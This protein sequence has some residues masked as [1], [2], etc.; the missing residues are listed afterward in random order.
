VTLEE[1]AV[2]EGLVVDPKGQPVPLARVAKDAVPVV[3]VSGTLPPGVAETDA[4]GKFRLGELPSGLVTLEAFAPG[5]GQVLTQLRLY[6]GRTSKD[7]KLTLGE[8]ARGEPEAKGSGG[9][10]VTLGE[11]AGPPAEVGIVTV[12]EGSSAERAGLAPGDVIVEVSGV[13]VHTIA[14]ARGRLT[15]PLA[16]DVVLKVRRGE[17]PLTVRVSREEVRR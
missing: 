17:A 6:S 5:R 1:E 16:D 2:V 3:L 9:V 15:G 14:E 8:K 12:V 7:V 13:P 4:R 10:A 11:R